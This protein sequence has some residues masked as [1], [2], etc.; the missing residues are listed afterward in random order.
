M[1]PFDVL[2]IWAI[3]AAAG[4]VLAAVVFLLDR[5]QARRRAAGLG[6]DD[7]ASGLDRTARAAAR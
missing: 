7:R 6:G 2:T 5:A 1:T 4:L 3:G